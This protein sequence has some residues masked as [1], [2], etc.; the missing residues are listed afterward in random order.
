M[1]RRL[2]RA[3]FG[4]L[5]TLDLHGLGVKDAL[6]ETERFVRQAASAG[7]ERVRIVYGKGRGSPGGLGVLRQVVPRW[8]EGEGKAWVERIE[9]QLDA[10]GD[11]G[12]VVVWLR[13]TE[14]KIKRQEEESAALPRRDDFPSSILSAFLLFR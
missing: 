4:V 10:T 9:R 12:A 11:D 3:L 14:K 2:L 1:I 5:P 13:R 8:L 7:E 6:A